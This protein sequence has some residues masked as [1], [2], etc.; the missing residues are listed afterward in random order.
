MPSH[1]E[2]LMETQKPFIAAETIV[3]SRDREQRGVATGNTHECAMYG[4]SGLR[5]SVRWPDG[6]ITFPCSKGMTVRKN[7]DWEFL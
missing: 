2:H 6:R 7:G 3:H 1:E 4:C 5:V